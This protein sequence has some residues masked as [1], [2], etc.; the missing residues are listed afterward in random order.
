MNFAERDQLLRTFIM[1][2]L[3][4]LEHA[5]SLLAS[6]QV[7]FHKLISDTHWQ[8]LDA[9]DHIKLADLIE[10]AVT[11]YHNGEITAHDAAA[12]ILI[13]ASSE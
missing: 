5:P 11:L 8:P 3:S 2:S 13:A 9:E 7:Q 1:M 12:L 6:V 4:H 10:D